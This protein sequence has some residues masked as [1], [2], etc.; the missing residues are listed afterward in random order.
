MELSHD[1]NEL[2]G[3]FLSRNVE[4][5]VVGAH[6]LAHHGVPR[7]TGDLDILVRP[8]EENAARIVAALED[9]GFSD[10]GLSKSDFTTPDAVIQLGRAPARVDILTTITGVSWKDAA[11]GSAEG[12]VGTNHVRFLGRAELITNKQATGRTKDLADIE[13]LGP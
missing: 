13:A 12:T 10:L 11:A 8:T 7:F 5:I 6:A 9:F 3:S 1:L 4:F 2:L